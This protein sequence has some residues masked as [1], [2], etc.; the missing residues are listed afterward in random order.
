LSCSRTG[1][2]LRASKSLRPCWMTFL[3]IP[4]GYWHWN[5]LGYIRAFLWEIFNRP[6]E[7]CS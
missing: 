6:R 4:V 2:T 3:I 7:Q 1:S 5:L